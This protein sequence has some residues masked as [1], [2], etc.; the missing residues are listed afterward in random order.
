VPIKTSRHQTIAMATVSA[1]VK[2]A[3]CSAIVRTWAA[4][5]TVP[6]WEAR[7]RSMLCRIELRR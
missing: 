7:E 6:G 1:T 4:F 3:T 5:S 2:K